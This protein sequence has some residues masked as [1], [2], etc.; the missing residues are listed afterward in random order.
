M[1]LRRPF[2]CMNNDNDNDNDNGLRPLFR[3]RV[4]GIPTLLPS[5]CVGGALLFL[6]SVEVSEQLQ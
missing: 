2:D 1:H 5:G 4:E 3:C 6:P